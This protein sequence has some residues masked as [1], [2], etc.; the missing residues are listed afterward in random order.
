MLP[1]KEQPLTDGI[2]GETPIDDKTI[3]VSLPNFNEPIVIKAE[4]NHSIDWNS[5]YPEN[6]VPDDDNYSGGKEGS[7]QPAII[8]SGLLYPESGDVELEI[9]GHSSPDGSNGEIYSSL[10]KLTS[11]KNIV[12]NIR[13]TVN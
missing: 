9:I 1:T 10:E 6:A 12:K 3:K 2:S 5:Y 8:Y 11:A 7:G 13:V 4:F